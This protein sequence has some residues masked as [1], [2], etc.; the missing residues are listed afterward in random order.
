MNPF[1]FRPR[2]NPSRTIY[3]SPKVCVTS[4]HW[5]NAGEVTQKTTQPEA[6][7]EWLNM[8]ALCKIR[9]VIHIGHVLLPNAKAVS[10]EILASVL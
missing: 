4:L 9:V 1:A 8:V 5:T 6:Q 10:I 3:A 7:R 2:Q